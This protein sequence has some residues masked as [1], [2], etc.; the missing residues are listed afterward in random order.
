MPSRRET[1]GAELTVD[2]RRL[3]TKLRQ[4]ERVVAKSSGVMRRELN[5]VDSGAARM[6]GGAVARGTRGRRM[7]GAAIGMGG[8]GVGGMLKGAATF[9]GIYGIVGEIKKAKQFEE[10]LVD[11]SVRGGKSKKWMDR[12]RASMLATSNEFG[13]GK[14]QLAA[15]VG[16]IIDQT[17]NTQ[18]ATE[19]L[20]SMTAVAYSAN[21]PMG[22]LAGTVV[23]LQSKLGL[24]PKQFE[25]ALGI[26]A[27]QADKGKVPLSQMSQ[28]LPEVLN[29][30]TQFGHTGV[31]ALRDY[32]AVL[33]MAARGAGSLAEANTAMNRML[34]QTAAK[35]AKIE[36]TL[37]IKLKRNGAW[38]QLGPMLKEIVAGLLKMKAEGKDVEKFIVSTWGIRG[39]KAILPMMQQGAKGWGGRVGSDASGQGGLTSFDALVGAG[40]AGTIQERVARKRKLSPELD[41]WNK[42][43]EKLKNK[44]HT[45]LLPALKKLGDIM[46]QIGRALEWMIDN[47]RTLLAMWAGAKMVRVFGMFRGLLGGG[48]G[49]GLMSMLGGGGGVATAG[50]GAATT[51]TAATIGGGGLAGGLTAA[52]AALGG[53]TLAIAPAIAGLHELGKAYTEE[54]KKK[55]RKRIMALERGVAAGDLTGLEELRRLRAQLIRGKYEKEG[56]LAP[57]GPFGGGA[58]GGAGPSAEVKS[59]QALGVSRTETKDLIKAYDLMYS[60]KT[61]K[62]SGMLADFGTERLKKL[63]GGEEYQ[64]RQAGLSKAAVQEMAALATASPQQMDAIER[65]WVKVADV[66]DARLKALKLTV[67]IA[68]PKNTPKGVTDSRR[69]AK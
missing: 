51:G 38:M 33:Q 25:E 65:G 48:G 43:V 39:K 10:V 21:V 58:Y 12:L 56:L 69:N 57:G 41:K 66:V 68:D 36:K 50:G 53:F 59:R 16:T 44:L 54:G 13:V 45:H 37:G 52:S 42:S 67:T 17:G 23:E 26:L 27:A 8:G 62:A 32:G 31:G 28:Y 61:G 1:I 35:R 55:T 24:A 6:G 64:L 49:G 34:D 29:A 18:L 2:N 15:Y 5:R 14:D 11:I 47:W 7:T 60:G 20:R 3:R 9:G 4:S 63:A 22:Q 19:T 46:P 40:G 30:T